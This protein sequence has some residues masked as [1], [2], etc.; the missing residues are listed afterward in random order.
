MGRSVCFRMS[1]A[2]QSAQKKAAK[3]AT[4]FEGPCTPTFLDWKRICPPF[5][6]FVRLFTDSKQS[7]PKDHGTGVFVVLGIPQF[8]DPANESRAGLLERFGGAA[9]LGNPEVVNFLLASLQNHSKRG[10]PHKTP[11]WM[12]HFS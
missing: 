6:Y 7:R 12:A 5:V 4:V 3:T 11:V 1:F 8:Q 9:K 2:A 10:L